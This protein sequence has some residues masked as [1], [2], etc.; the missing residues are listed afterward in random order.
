MLATSTRSGWLS[1]IAATL[2]PLTELLRREVI[3][4]CDVLHGDDTSILVL[5]LAR[6]RRAPDSCGPMCETNAPTTAFV[7]Q[8][9]CSLPRP[10]VGA[11]ARSPT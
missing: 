11:S 2:Q 10:T 3:G 4:G 6:A 8:Q 5:A 7:R 9:L 1:A